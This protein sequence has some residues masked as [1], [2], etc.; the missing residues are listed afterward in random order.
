MAAAKFSSV[1]RTSLSARLISSSLD[2]SPVKITVA[3]T[4]TVS[5]PYPV[6]GRSAC[7]TAGAR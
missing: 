3:E 4:E 6:R 1:S 5:G 2:N 7:R